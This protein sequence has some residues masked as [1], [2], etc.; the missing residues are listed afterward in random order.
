MGWP[1][2][3]QMLRR[4]LVLDLSVAFG[5]SEFLGCTE[6]RNSS[7][8]APLSDEFVGFETKQRTDGYIGIGLGTAAGYWFWCVIALWDFKCGACVLIGHLGTDITF[9]PSADATPFIRSSRSN[10][11]R[12]RTHR[13]GWRAGR[14]SN[15]WWEEEEENSWDIWRG[16]VV[17]RGWKLYKSSSISRV[18]PSVNYRKN[19]LLSPKLPVKVWC[20]PAGSLEAAPADLQCLKWR[21]CWNLLPKKIKMLCTA[22]MNLSQTRY[23]TH[24]NLKLSSISYLVVLTGSSKV[25][26]GSAVICTFFQDSLLITTKWKAKSSKASQ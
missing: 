3:P 5:K 2:L 16:M 25:P 9:L 22:L 8:I 4:G 18:N 1:F 15:R 20:R 11:P 19:T 6:V 12:M 17:F 23:K 14:V 24:C 10:E 21:I 26:F 13:C 7:W